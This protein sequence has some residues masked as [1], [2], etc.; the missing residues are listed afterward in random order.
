MFIGGDARK[1]IQVAWTLQS[2]LCKRVDTATASAC[3]TTTTVL[4]G[5]A[6]IHCSS[7][8]HTNQL[9]LAAAALVPA[10]VTA[11]VCK[12]SS[13]HVVTSAVSSLQ[14][15]E[16]DI[17]AMAAAGASSVSNGGCMPDD[18][19]HLIG[20]PEEDRPRLEKFL[21]RMHDT[22]SQECSWTL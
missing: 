7:A 16:I 4:F 11:G 21:N 3:I 9:A 10:Y 5:Q 13:A 17:R 18:I 15:L 2:Q 14:G 1:H 20:D 12:S 6:C 8:L 22:G 19:L